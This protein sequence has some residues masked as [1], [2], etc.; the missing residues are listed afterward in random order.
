VT[1]ATHVAHPHI[2]NHGLADGC[3]RCAEIAADPIANLDD[4]N[5][6]DLI[7]RTIMWRGDKEFPRSDNELRAMRE[8][9]KILVAVERVE[10]IMRKEV[11]A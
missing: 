8:M 11:V 7:N 6:I 4:K 9:E 1:S 2:I 3:E 10:Q 5:L